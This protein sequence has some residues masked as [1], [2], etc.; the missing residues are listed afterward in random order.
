MALSNSRS[1]LPYDRMLPGRAV[2]LPV[3]QGV[4]IQILAENPAWG[5]K[6]NKLPGLALIE[7]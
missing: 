2:K 4:A 5:W 7:A 1:H 6:C 3:A